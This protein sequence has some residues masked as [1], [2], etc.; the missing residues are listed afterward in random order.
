MK[1]DVVLVDEKCRLVVG[2]AKA[3][4]YDLTVRESAA[5]MPHETVAVPAGVK[6]AIPNGYV[7]FIAPRSSS[8][9]KKKLDISGVIDSDYRGEI[10]VM[11]HN[12][13]SKEFV[14]ERYARLAQML[15]IEAKNFPVNYVNELDVT[16]RG[17]KG[18]GSSGEKGETK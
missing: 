1:L 9:L 10:K 16:A 4:G 7:G 12:N 3:G 11:I 8:F 13:S 14:I 6:V 15:I 18:F 5:V 2:S 17:E